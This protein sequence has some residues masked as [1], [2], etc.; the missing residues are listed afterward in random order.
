M[1]TEYQGADE[2]LARTQNFVADHL[3]LYLESRGAAGHIMDFAHAGAPGFRSSLL[4][5]TIG[6]KSGRTSIVPLIYG[7]HGD[8]W[9]VIGSKGGADSHPAWYLNL[10]EQTDV[11]LQI[12][13]Q[14]FRATWRMPEGAEREAIWA[15]MEGVFPPYR[16]YAK[17]VTTRIIPVVMLKPQEAIAPLQKA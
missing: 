15:Y 9:V 13:T 2:L 5:A 10:R 8:E 14:A 12:A 3:D 17:A 7:G 16:D 6:R 1:T 4:L 11:A